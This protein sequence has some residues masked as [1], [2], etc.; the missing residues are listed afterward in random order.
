MAR[1]ND[2]ALHTRPSLLIRIRDAADI[3]GVRVSAHTFRHTFA[4]SLLEQGGEI[5]SLSRLLGHTNIQ[6]TDVYL[7]D[8]Q[9]RQARQHHAEYLPLA[10]FQPPR[11]NSK[12]PRPALPPAPTDGEAATGEE[13]AG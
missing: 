5:Y 6:I 8:F 3:E 10:S 13:S 9:A 4:C 12:R 11:N 1:G 7:R 2:S